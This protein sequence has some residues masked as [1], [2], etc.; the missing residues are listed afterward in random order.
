[1]SLLYLDSFDSYAT[2]DGPLRWDMGTS[3]YIN[4][5]S[6]D[7]YT[8]RQDSK[9]L[10]YRGTNVNQGKKRF[11]SGEVRDE[12]IVGYRH[13]YLHHQDIDGVMISF[14][15]TSGSQLA[16]R[17]YEDGS[18]SAWRGS[19]VNT[20]LADSKADILKNDS[21]DT[22]E[23]KV[24]IH[25]STGYWYIRVNGELVFSG[26]NYDTQ[27][28][29]SG[30]IDRIGIGGLGGGNQDHAYED[31]YICDLSGEFHND[32]VN[33]L[34]IDC[35]HPNANG[36]NTDWTPDSGDNYDRVNDGG[37]VD[38]GSSYV[39]SLTDGHVDTY[40]V[41]DLE[42]LS[43]ETTIEGVQVSTY[44]KDDEISGE[45]IPTFYDGTK[46]SG[47]GES[48]LQWL[49]MSEILQDDEEYYF[50]GAYCWE[51]DPGGGAWTQSTINSGEFGFELNIP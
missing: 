25:N 32:W 46:Y 7:P 29:S 15:N 44:V 24:K 39:Y 19:I 26:E 18:I 45:I 42:T 14:Q 11:L 16:F 37:N 13:A 43:G 12:L 2:G 41:D 20:R 23:F 48:T 8:L 35:L 5:E 22:I 47:S 31:L 40:L 50:K 28:Q 21:W 4:I 36:T 49:G 30:G 27:Y 38:L 10:Y 9:T 3:D 33:G 17:A 34:R 1:M 6:S 51:L